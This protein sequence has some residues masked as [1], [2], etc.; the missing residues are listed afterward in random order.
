MKYFLWISLLAIVPVQHNWTIL[1]EDLGYQGYN[2]D[3]I[4]VIL[5]HKK[6][7][8]GELTQQQKQ[9]NKH[10]SQIRVFVEHLMAGI[11]R[12]NIIKEKIRLRMQGV[13]D[14][15]MLIACGLHNLRTA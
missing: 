9:D 15:V 8:G 11:K 3:N 13:R 10:M 1:V 4:S 12:L 2:P 5:P 14:Q 7:K 6:P